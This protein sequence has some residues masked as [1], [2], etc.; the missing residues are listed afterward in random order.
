[1]NFTPNADNRK[2]FICYLAAAERSHHPQPTAERLWVHRTPLVVLDN[3]VVEAAAYNLVQVAFDREVARHT[4][5]SQGNLVLED[6]LG[7]VAEIHL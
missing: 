6:S 3:T 5:Y 4:E 2:Q 1:M 7:A